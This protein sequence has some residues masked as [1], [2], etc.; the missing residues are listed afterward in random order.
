MTTAAAAVATKQMGHNENPKT[1]V[2]GNE[3]IEIVTFTTM[4]EKIQIRK[5][6][7]NG[8]EEAKSSKLTQW[9]EEDNDSRKTRKKHIA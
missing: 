1:N 8:E 2:K 7:S 4:A 9:H 6:K 3:T 5:T